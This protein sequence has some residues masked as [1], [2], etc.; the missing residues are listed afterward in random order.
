MTN[1]KKM[2]VKKLIESVI[3]QLANNEPLS[4]LVPKLQVISKLLKNDKFKSWV[5][6]EFIYGYS[7][8][9]DIPDYRKITMSNVKA[10]FIQHQGFGRMMQYTNFDIPII[11]LGN[12]IYNEFASISIRQTVFSIDRI[13][14]ENKG[15]IHLS[16]TQYEKVLVQS[17]ILENCEISNISKIASREYFLNIISKAKAKLLDIFLE[18][19]ETVFENE[20]NFNVMEK[21]E[22]ISQ[23]VN[24]TI[25]TGVYVSENSTAN[26]NDSNILGGTKNQASFSPNFKS[27]VLE[28]IE[29]IDEL[30]KDVETDRDDIAYEISKIKLAL[31]KEESPKIIKSAFNAIKGIA[32]AVAA[33]EITEL[34]NQNLP[35]INF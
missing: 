8:N 14:K 35:N 18:L 9:S 24:N 21:K 4:E 33:N 11:N 31:E 25:N 32:N 16:L 2:D 27:E 1:F 30:S 3:Y 19:N 15:D 23:I 5:E 17:E 34:L 28:L 13:L 29:K 22:E 7:G 10:S 12:E 6:S 20:I 26:I